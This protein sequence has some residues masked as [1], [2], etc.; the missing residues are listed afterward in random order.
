[1][2]RLAKLKMRFGQRNPRPKPYRKEAPKRLGP[3]L[4]A[5]V[6]VALKAHE[7]DVQSVFTGIQRTQEEFPI[8]RMPHVQRITALDI[9]YV[10]LSSSCDRF[11]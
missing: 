11:G 3:L 6:T 2:H 9:I 5:R 4:C 10:S 7:I 8:R 1:M